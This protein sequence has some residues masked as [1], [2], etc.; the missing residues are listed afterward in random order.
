M[1]EFSEARGESES[2]LLLEW[3]V[4]SVGGWL[5]VGR[6]WRVET[7]RKT[8]EFL[9]FWYQ[10]VLGVRVDCVLGRAAVSVRMTRLNH[11]M[12]G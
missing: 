1:T 12:N 8:T 2:H 7:V 11:W 5:P 3:S 9:E 4:F 6:D 10:Q